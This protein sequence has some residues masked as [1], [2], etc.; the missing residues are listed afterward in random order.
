MPFLFRVLM[1]AILIPAA[2]F[3]KEFPDAGGVL[4]F[5]KPE[6][7]SNRLFILT[8]PKSG[9]HLLLYSIM[10]ITERPLRGRVPY[11]H[12]ENDPPFF[13]PENMMDYPVN[14]TKPTTYWGHEY[15]LLKP[16][17]HS[18]NQLIFI[19]RNYK[20][21]ISSQLVIKHRHNGEDIDLGNL[22]LNEVLNEGTVFKEYMLRLQ[23]FNDWNPH[24][25]CLVSFED[26][27]HHPEVFVPQVISFIGEA[28]EY[29]SFIDQYENFKHEL[30]ERYNK[31]NNRTGSGSDNHFF[32][33]KIPPDILQIVDHHVQANY[34]ELWNRYLKK[35]CEENIQE[36]L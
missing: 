32:S 26:L 5:S 16:L 1:Y 25:R 28:S 19:L 6:S 33:K 18:E 3:S 11:W 20:E 8:N 23:L 35:F 21:T 36:L 7:I 29:E 2:C 10:K 14:F 13:P 31:K 27:T 34:T 22:L 4:D 15:H 24:H 9:S 17:N 12:F 30:M